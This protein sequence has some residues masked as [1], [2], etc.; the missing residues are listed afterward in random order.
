MKRLIVVGGGIAGLTTALSVRDRAEAAGEPV[1]VV[2][3]EASPRVGGN[4][5]TDREDGYIVEWGPNGYLDNVATTPELIRRLRLE[6]ELQQADRSA[7][8]RFLYRNQRLHE[9][10]GGPLSFLFN[11]VLSVRGRLGVLGEPF[12]S[13]PPDGVDETVYEFARRRIG[14]EAA[15]VLVDAMVSGVFAGNA[16]EL[17]LASAFPKMAAMETEHGSLVKA[18]IAKMRARRAAKRRGDL[19]ALSRPGGPAGPGGTLTSFRDGL[20]VITGRLH[21]ELGSVVHTEQRVTR[22][23]AASPRPASESAR[24][25]RVELAGG[26]YF[27]G[28][29]VVLAL[30][31]P[32]TAPLLRELDD[33]L[34]EH[35]GAIRTAGLAVVALGYDQSDLERPVNGFGFLVPRG[36]GPR[37]LG[38]LWDSSIFPGRAATGRVL[39]RAMIGGAHHPEAVL[40]DDDELL[41]V[42]RADL[43][44]VMGLRAAPVFE[45]IYRHPLGISQYVVGH[46]AQ[47]ARIRGHL[48]RW[49]GLWVT[50]SSYDGVSMNACIESATSLASEVMSFLAR[51][52]RTLQGVTA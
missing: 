9:L 38:C 3:L 27:D 37:I 49:Q 25:W 17:S 24:A 23:R 44:T 26:K 36:E 5:R 39:M 52:R 1:E 12:A 45:R 51:S 29:A 22:L 19:D 35:I 20:D 28:D 46:A 42:V 14:E 11:P 10:P 32:K 2:L 6:G 50:G 43:Q 15:R 34:S 30:P 47:L 16:R 18:M 7:A 48:E 8:R 40:L 21:E 41:R 33:Q 4:I 31:A 13:G